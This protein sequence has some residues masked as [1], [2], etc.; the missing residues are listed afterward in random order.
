MRNTLPSFEASAAFLSTKYNCAS[1]IRLY[2]LSL[3][4]SHLQEYDIL[5][6]H[7]LPTFG[8]LPT[9]LLRS[10]R[11]GLGIL[12]YQQGRYHHNFL[13]FLKPATSSPYIAFW[14]INNGS[15]VLCSI[16][17]ETMCQGSI[18]AQP[19]PVVAVWPTPS[20]SPSRN[21]GCS[22]I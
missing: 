12:D 9:G 16:S 4:A 6:N 8:A 21:I 3:L 1:N 2:L 5:A 17:G 13:H 14:R 18:V 19:S 10:L 15:L 11:I 7:H 22:T 20:L